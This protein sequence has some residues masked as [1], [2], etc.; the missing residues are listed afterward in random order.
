[1]TIQNDVTKIMH[2]GY[3]VP[4]QKPTKK[5]MT[6][7][8]V[9]QASE[10]IQQYIK[11]LYSKSPMM[12]HFTKDRM[13]FTNPLITVGYDRGFGRGVQSSGKEF[14]IE[15]LQEKLKNKKLDKD[16]RSTIELEIK[17]Q[18][19]HGV[20]TPEQAAQWEKICERKIEEG[21]KK[22]DLKM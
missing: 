12:Y 13:S 21:R 19:Q 2:T 6:T 11:Q 20:L 4:V 1:M 5:P 15:V 22:F 16:M 17:R 9:K 14:P 7:K 18:Q 8:V 10:G 3:I